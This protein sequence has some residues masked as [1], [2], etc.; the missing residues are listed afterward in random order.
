MK[1]N[2]KTSLIAFIFFF[3][4]SSLCFSQKG[5]PNAPNPARGYNNY[6]KQFPNFLSKKQAKELEQKLT[7]FEKETSNEIVVVVVDNLAGYEPWDYATKLGDKWGVG[8]AKEDNGIVI[9]IKPTGGKGKRKTF[10]ATGKGLGG[11]IPDITCKEIVDNEMLPSFKNKKYFEGINKA[12]VVIT[13]LAKGEYNHKD[14]SKK[15]KKEMSLTNMILTI[16]FLG[17]IVFAFF[18]SVKKNG[19]FA[20]LAMIA[21]FSRGSS[22]GSGRG[23]GGS[24][25]GF[26]GGGFGGG[27]FGGG[28]AGG[29]W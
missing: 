22:I 21:I 18:W 24:G 3:L 14:Y 10:I 11:A 20:T 9:L 7:K 26:G 28:G 19:L 25:G 1:N 4:G 2:F 6:S 5:I 23:G 29:S 27:S 13:A 17:L 8:K 12:L 16:L 15:H